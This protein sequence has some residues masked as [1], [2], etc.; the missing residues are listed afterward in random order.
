M[1]AFVTLNEPIPNNVIVMNSKGINN[2]W[3]IS[4]KCQPQLCA[5]C[6]PPPAWHR[7]QTH[8]AGRRP[9]HGGPW[10]QAVVGVVGSVPPW[11]GG[12]GV[13]GVRLLRWLPPGLALASPPGRPPQSPFYGQEAG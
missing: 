1:D 6:P 2:D 13:G 5:A 3:A 11:G 8:P 12:E 9:R 4:I 10:P 7:F